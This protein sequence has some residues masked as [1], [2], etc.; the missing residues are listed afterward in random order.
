MKRLD[1]LSVCVLILLFA[2]PAGARQIQVGDGD[3]PYDLHVLHSDPERTTVRLELNS[4][5]LGDLE[6]AGDSWHTLQLARRAL[7]HDRGLPA[8][9]MLRESLIIPDAAAMH[10]RVIGEQYVDL[11]DVPVAPSKGTISRDLNPDLIKHEFADFYQRDAWYPSAAATL[12][13]PYIMRDTRGLVL[14]LNPFQ[15]NPASQTLR[16][17]TSLTVE[18]YADGPGQVNV[19]EQRPPNQPQEFEKIY[20][21]HYLNYDGAR[22]TRY[23]SIPEVGPMLVITY[24]AF[25]G[26]V[27]PF[28]D[29]KNQMGIPT[30]LVDLSTIGGTSTLIKAYIENL[31]NTTGVCFVV[32]VGDAAQVPYYNNG[33]A[34]DPSYAFLAGSDYYPEIFIGRLSAENVNQLAT[35]VERSIEYERDP[36]M[37]ADW[38]GKGIGIGSSEGAGNGD[39]GEADYVH[40]DNIRTD[41]L[42]FTYTEVDQVYDPGASAAAV[43][44]GCN[45]GRS[46]INYCGHGWIQGWSTTGFNNSNVNALTNDNLLPFITSVACNTGEFQ[47]GTCFGEAWMRATNGGEPAGAV[48]FYGSTISMSWAPPMCG[49]DE[50]VDLMVSGEKRTFGGLCFNGS[51]QMVDEYGS[52]GQNEMK[53]WTIF[54]DPSL[55]VRTGTTEATT[56]S[57]FGTVDPMMG[58]FTV[59]TEPENLVAISYQGALI[60]SAI[61]GHEGEA[62]VVFEGE[63]PMPG[64]DVTLTVTGF[65]RQTH[66][67]EVLVGDSLLP[68]C[69]VDPSYF[70]LVML[71]DQE[72]TD[73]LHIANNGEEGSTLYY[74]IAISDPDFPVAKGT[75]ALQ[76]NMTGSNAWAEPDAVYP[77]TTLDI[78]VF[79]Y[80]GSPDAEWVDRF[81]MQL[82]DGVVLNSATTLAGGSGGDLPYVGELGNGAF[83]DWEVPSGWGYIYGNETGEATLNVSFEAMGD[84]VTIPYTIYGDDYGGDPHSVS[85]E[86]TIGTL[87]PNVTVLEPNGGELCSIGGRQMIR[88]SAGGGP[89]LV[90]IELTRDGVSWE[91]LADGFAAD[92]GMFSWTVDGAITPHARVR[93]TDSADPT[94]TDTS[95]GDFTVYRTLTWVRMSTTAGSVL[96]GD[97]TSL[98]VTFDSTGLPDGDYAA[99]IKVLSNAGDPVVVPV[100]IQVAF[101]PSAVRE[102]PATMALSQNHPN[103]FNPS[104]LISFNLPQAGQAVLRV[105]DVQG[106]LVDTLLEEDLPAG[107]HHVVWNGTGT[108][109]S[110]V[111]SGVYFYRVEAE[112]NMLTKK[113]LLLK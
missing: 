76:R 74:S 30:T 16:V 19:L 61:A 2:L 111:P 50:I 41:L 6:I 25:H 34:S 63:L 4:F 82:P 56:V 102:V 54:G 24:D 29:W 86:I 104:T 84:G 66:V 47:S 32:L 65:N 22:A 48:G 44:A 108:D 18:V 107:A 15:Y 91:P 96:Q 31:Y 98:E 14:E 28:V 5:E 72:Q 103:P 95:D 70:D 71:P 79:V 87:G 17:Y 35:Q 93:V 23:T 8:L 81:T 26:A 46:I 78:S 94:V 106:R 39:D 42:N 112:G 113:M 90:D 45:D 99:E 97:M 13:A 101:D 7:H 11:P 77:G 85:G 92:A 49:Q 83:C 33:G 89:T 60:G 109:G 38:Y 51:C 59:N 105:F 10:L 40:I 27:Q 1:V 68:T 37:G 69:D 52:S 36:Q 53:F 110:T 57:H 3:T 67:E 80:N 73:Y 9:P 55:R 20:Q 88:W 75:A 12:D 100:S 62:I 43:T 58:S 64:N 21:R